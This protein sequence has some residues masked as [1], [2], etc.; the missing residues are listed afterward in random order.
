MAFGVGLHRCLG[1]N[2]AR[3]MFQVMIDEI[4][5]RLPDFEITVAEVPRFDDAG[6]VYAPS[7]RKNRSEPALSVA[8]DG[9]NRDRHRRQ[10][11][12][13]PP[14]PDRVPRQLFVVGRSPSLFGASYHGWWP[15]GRGSWRFSV[16]RWKA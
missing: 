9:Q 8:P 16:I 6:N 13:W 2:L 15:R 3:M 1:S 11:R 10:D 14:V 7:R 4:L 5:D 12:S